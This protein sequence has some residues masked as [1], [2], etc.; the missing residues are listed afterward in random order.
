MNTPD[1]P[2]LQTM[3]RY[4]LGQAY[5]REHRLM[6]IG[7][8]DAPRDRVL[9]YTSFGITNVLLSS[10]TLWLGS[11]IFPDRRFQ[12]LALA[13]VVEMGVYLAFILIALFGVTLLWTAWRVSRAAR[14]G[15]DTDACDPLRRAVMRRA[16]R[17]AARHG[18]IHE[19]DGKLIFDRRHEGP[20]TP[21]P[22]AERR[23]HAQPAGVAYYPLDRLKAPPIRKEG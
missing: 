22:S 10:G 18:W 21:A 8:Y 11:M 14:R 17:W 23:H 13:G 5:W 2:T 3:W 15:E 4:H 20:P 12:E 1:L 16:F 9:Q 19:V 6:T 7:L